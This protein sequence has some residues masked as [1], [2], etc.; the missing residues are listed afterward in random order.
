[1]ESVFSGITNTKSKGSITRDETGSEDVDVQT[2]IVVK[3]DPRRC[4]PMTLIVSN[5][6]DDAFTLDSATQY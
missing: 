1:M 5:N 4:Y 6:F 2:F 3:A